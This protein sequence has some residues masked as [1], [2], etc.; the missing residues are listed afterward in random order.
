M[1]YLRLLKWLEKYKRKYLTYIKIEKLYS[2]KK[3]MI[4]AL[5]IYQI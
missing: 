5:S 4:V 3:E 2:K 1:Y